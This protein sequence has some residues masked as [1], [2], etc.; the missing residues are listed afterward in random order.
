MVDNYNEMM[1][2][3]IESDLTS[4]ADPGG[5]RLSGSGR[6]LVAEWTM[7]G[8][9]REATFTV[10]Q[11]RGITVIFDNTIQPYAAF[12]AGTPMADLRH[13]ARMIERT[14]TRD[15][16]IPTK[17]HR[18]DT[19]TEDRRSATDLLSDLLE[20]H[21]A[22]LTQVLMVT[23]EAGAGKTRIL[24]EL[25]LRQANRYLHGQTDKL[26]LY[27]N[28]QGRALARLN[29]ALATELQ[30]LRVHLTYHS[31]ATLTRVGL[32]V[33][34]IDGFDEL[35][36]V[37][38]YD[39]AFNSLATFLA[40]LEGDGSLIAS[41][42]SV[43]YE[44]EFLSR[45]SRVSTRGEQAWS[46]I[47]IEIVPWSDDDR[48]LFLE[49][50]TKRESLPEQERTQ[51]R[52]KVKEVFRGNEEL[53]SKP[54]FFVRTIDLLLRDPDF[55]GGEDLLG[56]LTHR[57]LER[58]QQEKLLDRQQ[59]PL[60]SEAYLQQLMSEL[61]EEM[62]NQETR[63][64]DPASVREVAEYILDEQD[65]P[66]ATRQIV[67]QR[68]PTLAFLSSNERHAGIV[69]E[70]EVFFFHFL[71]RAI[72]NQYIQ[73][74][75]MRVILSRS[76]LPEFVAE[77]LAFELGAR[78]RLN[79]L[80][81]L[82]QILDRL[83]EAGKT[84]WRRV[85]QVRENAGLIVMALLREFSKRRGEGYEIEGCTVCTLTFPGSHLGDVTLRKCALIDVWIHRTDL[86][87]TKLIECEAREVHLEEVKVKIGST[88][89]ELNGL[90]VPEEVSGIQVWGEQGSETVYGPR[91]IARVLGECGAVV[92]VT[93]E[94]E[95]R[96]VPSGLRT[97]LE[98]LMRAY[99]RTNP[100]CVGDER[101]KGLL[102]DPGWPVLRKHLIGNGIVK[103]EKRATSG[104]PKEFLR[105]QFLSADIMMG[106]SKV[107][108]VEPQIV[109]F[110]DSLEA[111]GA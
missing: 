76:S 103:P 22:D 69:F 36:G 30:D 111:E 96:E 42:R 7:R 68:M 28:A 52:A 1:R 61:A 92:E 82:Q 56:T 67:V 39:D 106:E 51:L 79:T 88:R 91:E 3:R 72:V 31:V 81:A 8:E 100:V 15:I 33:P 17:A 12:L 99:E 10:S 47:P 105:R 71:A 74:R 53:E 95:T 107:R 89:L 108:G 60:L 40:Q 29:E 20:N 2:G 6:R 90:R 66:E 14:G 5:V 98:R 97:L 58:E 4:F 21:E 50:L 23:G 35:L 64:L 80:E 104:R 49:E 83:T 26:L 9:P 87:T 44:D 41:A 93:E 48:R 75:D 70:H 78:Q 43:Y 32:L 86:A 25:V 38:G 18:T 101:L 94:T 37:S 54:L 102:S 34:V 46:H 77:R 45:A 85:A 13:M 57:F 109:R 84:E 19:H 11:E 16:F 62:W 110:W 65:V 24:Q 59:R 55:A 73:D 63:E 27:V